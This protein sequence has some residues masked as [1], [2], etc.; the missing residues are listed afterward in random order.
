MSFQG[1]DVFRL[2]HT[3]SLSLRV[4]N[5]R[6]SP[7]HTGHLSAHFSPLHVEALIGDPG[8]R[9][10]STCCRKEVGTN[11]R[12]CR[13]WKHSIEQVAQRLRP[14]VRSVVNVRTRIQAE[15]Q[16]GESQAKP[17]SNE[18]VEQRSGAAC[19]SVDPPS[20]QLTLTRLKWWI[21]NKRGSGRLWYT[22]YLVG[23][24]GD[25]AMIDTSG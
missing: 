3:C 19:L 23:H 14:T 4:M 17:D 9:Q 6:G 5:G 20:P 22:V 16:R 7:V 11:R 24:G 25:P 15:L 12:I 1:S 8:P 21:T 2:V 13:T 18:G 10:P